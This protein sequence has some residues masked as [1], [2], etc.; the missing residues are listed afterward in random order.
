MK[1]VGFL[2]AA[3]AV[4]LTAATASA[5]PI[6]PNVTVG[7]LPAATF[8]GSGI[9]NDAVAVTTAYPGGN[10][11]TLGLTATARFANLPVANDGSATFF[12]DPGG[13]ILNSAPLYGRWNFDFY[14]NQTGGNYSYELLYDLDP[15]VGTLESDLGTVSFALAG[16]STFQDSWNLG[17]GFLRTGLPGVIP[18]AYLPAFDPNAAG[19][20]SFALIAMDGST[21]IGRAAIN[22]NTT[23]A[24]EP[25]PEP[26]SMVLLGSGLAGLVAQRR[27]KM[28]SAN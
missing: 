20:Y 23:P 25:V 10:T 5:G 15:G 19:E 14:T 24:P 22:V 4:F 13:D 8:G 16:A 12:A 9:P 21:E 6:V 26:A 7:P 27:K 3:F 17:F 1:H 2:S 18:P 28:A 11:V